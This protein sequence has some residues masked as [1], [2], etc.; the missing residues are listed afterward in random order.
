MSMKPKRF[1]EAIGL[2]TG[3]LV[4]PVFAV[5]SMLRQNRV[6][7]PKGIHFRANVTAVENVEEKFAEIATSLARHDTL[8]RFSTGRPSRERT[9][10]PD[11][12]GI[13]IRFGAERGENFQPRDDAQ[14][15]LLMTAESVLSLAKGAISTNQQNFA[16]N[17]YHGG[18]PFEI[19]EQPNMLVRL[20][21]MSHVE[22]S[23]TDRYQNLRHAVEEG[24]VI[25]RLEVASMSQP[26]KWYPLVEIRLMNEVQVDDSK[27]ELWPF[28]TGRGIVPQGFVQY[29]RQMP[30]L[31]SEYGR[32]I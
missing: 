29:T 20:V 1:S 32:N 6:F 3:G 21:P 2:W 30:Y 11:I 19:A 17:I 22:T 15:L 27:L 8:V 9:I 28:R 31:F 13:S 26:N 12:H 24:D 10:L 4:A 16:G 14:D 25:F 5:G 7:H 18:A 23:G